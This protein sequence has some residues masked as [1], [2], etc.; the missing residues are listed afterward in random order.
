MSR[1]TIGALGAAVLLSGVLAFVLLSGLGGAASASVEQGDS[2]GFLARFQARQFPNEMPP[3]DDWVVRQSLGIPVDASPE[4][5]DALL[6]EWYQ[7][8]DRKNEKGGPNPIAYAERMDALAKAEAQGLSPM[9]AN[10]ALTGTAQMLMIPI[11]FA[12]TDVLS[13][14]EPVSGTFSYTVTVAGP[15]NG[16]IPDPGT[17]GV[18]D[19]FDIWTDTFSVE[20]YQDLMFGDGIGVVRRDLNS[21]AGID[22]TGVSAAKWYEEQSEG[23]FTLAG[24]VYTAWVQLDHSV[25]WYGWE[26]GEGDPDG[27]GINCGGVPAGSAN[28]FVIDTIAK[29]NATNPNFDWGKYD[30]DG[31][32]FVDHLMFIHAGSDNSGGGGTYGDFQMWA[33]SWDVACDNDGDGTDRK[34]VV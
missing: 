28:T 29:L 3:V 32:G 33:H 10:L 15:L 22:L 9:A 12:G 8:F 31:D 6:R 5:V 14:C 2:S 23:E 13:A 17:P 4:E 19:N 27:T 24:D 30:V 7:D 16:T 26:G 25:A 18:N 20:W 11:E 1:K 21:G 34:S